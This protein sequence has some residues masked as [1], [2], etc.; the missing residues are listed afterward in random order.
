MMSVTL[1]CKISR[2]FI[3]FA[4]LLIHFSARSQVLNAGSATGLP[5]NVSFHSGD[6]DSI[7]LNG[8]SQHIEISAVYRRGERT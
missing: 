4:F 1:R 6:I 5:P 8:L 7:N 3:A 2:A